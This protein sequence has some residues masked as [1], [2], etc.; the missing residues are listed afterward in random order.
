MT[1]SARWALALGV[2]VLAVLVALLPRT[3]NGGDSDGPPAE[4]GVAERLAAARQQA[5]LP[6]CPT[7]RAGAEPV[8]ALHDVRADCLGDGSV[9]ELGTALAGRTTLINIWATWCAPCRAELPVLAEYAAS[10]G[11][12]DV[13]PVQVAS[14]AAGGLELLAVLGVRLPSLHDGAGER[15]P[16]RAALRVPRTLPASYL[17]TAD[18]EIR[19]I[20]NPRLLRS[21]EEV[22]RAVEVYGGAR[23]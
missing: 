14:D 13:L 3:G 11:A 2:L 4:Q 9:V 16:I 5:A 10:P 20:E 15:G 7:A 18:G 17:V 19:F 21:V 12:V 6:P 23:E 8:P 1:N 22:G